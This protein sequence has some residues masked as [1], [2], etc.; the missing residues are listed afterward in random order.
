MTLTAFPPTYLMSYEDTN[1]NQVAIIQS[2]KGY[3]AEQSTISDHYSD[4]LVLIMKSI[5]VSL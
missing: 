4:K 1:G 3:S 5:I 2:R